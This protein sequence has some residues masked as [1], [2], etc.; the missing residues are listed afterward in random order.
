MQKG[1]EDKK[2]EVFRK[3]II[4][5]TKIENNV[6]KWIFTFKR[7]KK[8]SGK[9]GKCLDLD[10]MVFKLFISVHSVLA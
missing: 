6:Q 5:R 8:C 2:M 3:K 10:E 9:F 4:T 1:I 7:G